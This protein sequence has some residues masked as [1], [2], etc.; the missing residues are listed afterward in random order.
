MLI[1]ILI[2]QNQAAC[3]QFKLWTELRCYQSP[4]PK[5]DYNVKNSNKAAKIMIANFY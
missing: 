4:L 2:V 5:S 1:N 3:F